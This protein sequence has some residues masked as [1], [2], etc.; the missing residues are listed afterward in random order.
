M[1]VLD[2]PSSR[3]KSQNAVGRAS[4]RRL[5]DLSTHSEVFHTRMKPNGSRGRGGFAER[6]RR[7]AGDEWT[8]A[9]PLM[10]DL[11]LQ[12]LLKP[13]VENKVKVL[14]AVDKFEVAR[15]MPKSFSKTYH[16]RKHI[17]SQ[18]KRENEWS[19]FTSTIDR[20]AKMPWTGTPPLDFEDELPGVEKHYNETSWL[21][22]KIPQISAASR[23]TD[24]ISGANLKR[25]MKEKLVMQEGEGSD[26]VIGVTNP[27]LVA[28][29]RLQEEREREEKKRLELLQ[30]EEEEFL[31]L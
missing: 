27:Q 8:P 2:R 30:Q 13:M 28:Y 11:D 19:V 29:L 25:F 12:S 23:F 15:R 9:T 16:V 3:P 22:G 4:R 26:R 7:D 10:R 14:T 31:E 24:D 21:H 17:A 5:P 1:L 20:E 18:Q 6:N